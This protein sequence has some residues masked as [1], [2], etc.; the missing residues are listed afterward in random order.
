MNTSASRFG[1]YGQMDTNFSLDLV[2]MVIWP[3]T[4][5]VIIR[6]RYTSQNGYSIELK[7]A[8]FISVF[9]NN[10]Q[11]RLSAGFSILLA[12]F[13]PLRTIS[14]QNSSNCAGL[15]NRNLCQ[16]TSFVVFN[17]KSFWLINCKTRSK[18]SNIRQFK[19]QAHIKSHSLCTQ[20]IS[21]IKEVKC[22]S[23]KCEF[24]I[25]LKRR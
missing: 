20:A 4:D 17:F 12:K 24:L 15:L 11:N 7:K 6:K 1:H 14:S 5:N 22:K 16:L 9:N 19:I 18:S 13:A 23:N 10:F 25:I 3:C 8:Y 2:S 21:F